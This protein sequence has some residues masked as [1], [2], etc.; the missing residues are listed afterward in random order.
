MPYRPLPGT[1]RRAHPLCARQCCARPPGPVHTNRRGS[2]RAQ[3]HFVHAHVVHANA[4]YVYTVQ[5][6]VMHVSKEGEK[7]QSNR[8]S[9]ES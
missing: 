2:L 1:G 9:K 3:A 7:G 5:E 8:V 4:V 6:H